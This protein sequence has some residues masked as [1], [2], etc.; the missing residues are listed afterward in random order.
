M[1][2][3]LSG[4]DALNCPFTIIDSGRSL[5]EVIPRW[6]YG[7]VAHPA[8]VITPNTE[9]DIVSAIKFA[10]QNDLHIFAASG[11]HSTFASIDSKTVYLD[12]KALKSIQ[13]DKSTS[14]VRI[15][16]GTL[17]GE[18]LRSLV[19]EGYYTTVPNSNA[20]GVI[21]AVLGGGNT[22]QNG[23]HGF[24]VDNALSF[25]LI[26]AEGERL[27]VSSSS[28]GDELALYNLLC[29]A[30]HGVGVVTA[31]T[32]KVYPIAD[33][34]LPDNK[35]WTRTLFFSPPALDEVAEVFSTWQP[36]DGRL[37]VG[38]TFARSPPGTPAAGQPMII[39]SETFYGP[40]ED[41]EKEVAKFF[42]ETLVQKAVNQGTVMLPLSDLNNALEPLNAHGGFKSMNSARLNAMTPEALRESF[43]LWVKTTDPLP[44][45]S[46]SGLIFHKFDP[47]RLRAN[48]STKEHA[49]KFLES[50]DRGSTAMVMAWSGTQESHEKLLAF[51]DAFLEICRRGDS[52]VPRTFP[53]TMRSNTDLDE[54]FVVE[55]VAD[56]KRL[57]GKYD[58]QGVFWSPYN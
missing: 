46:R 41:A 24:M 43:D 9:D 8:I 20:V 40:P 53:N 13:L 55:K 21:G 22:S 37:N 38:V 28:E 52:G 47:S 49:N 54:L 27:E 19:S 48:G 7:N 44:D 5:G 3:S 42:N 11:G 58:P 6:S 25:C 35:I 18:L 36:Q 14:T 17:T 34:Q 10:K 29:G 1:A 57:K 32:M 4:T 15:S 39:L 2:S 26:T 23:L 45:T 30:G 50:R 12:L 16:A 51:V 31:L 33:L 56:L